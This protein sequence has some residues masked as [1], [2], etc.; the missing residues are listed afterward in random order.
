MKREPGFYRQVA[1][2]A[3]PIVAQNFITSALGMA[4]T[5]MVGMLGEIPMAG[6]TLANIP[7]FVVQLFFFGVQSGSTV[8][9]S[10]FWGRRDTDAINRVIG[11][12]WYVVGAVSLAFAAILLLAAEPF[13]GLFGN[14]PEVVA[15]AAR[16]ARIVGPSYIFNGLTLVYVGAHRSMENPKLGLYVFSASMCTNTFLNWVLIFGNLGVQPFGVEGAA[17]ATLISRVLEFLIMVFHIAF[18]KTFRLKASLLLRPGMGTVRKAVK[19]ASPVV[20]NETLWGLG[21]GLYATIMGHMEGSAEILAAYTIAGNVDKL[22]Q[23]VVFGIAGTAAVIIGREIGAGRTKT[24]YAV[25]L[26]LDT[27]AVLSGVVIGG[28]LLLLT[29]LW[30]PGTLFPL[31]RLSQGAA[32]TARMML[33]MLALMMPLRDFNSANIVGILRG[34]GDVR[35]ATLIDLSPLWLV[36]I[37]SAALAGLV[38]Q[39][40]IFW[41]YVALSLE[42]VVKCVFGVLRLRS[43]KWINDVTVGETA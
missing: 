21:N 36:A 42:Q 26:A 16:Y 33:T 43:G 40:G 17:I 35:A 12:C 8:L 27:L 2:L 5:F 1:A 15:V 22:C 10:Q 37:P 38:L 6:L 14:D 4:D 7:I 30:M 34:G 24:V 39:W 19:Y 23:V 25:G 29:H 28:G 20:L 13:M 41:V 32:D 11:V 18:G 3:A 31:F 9:I